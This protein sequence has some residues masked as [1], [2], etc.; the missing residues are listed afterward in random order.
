MRCHL[1]GEGECEGDGEGGMQTKGWRDRRAQ[2]L[3][4]T[5]RSQQYAISGGDS[6]RSCEYRT[7]YR[8]YLADSAAPQITPY[9]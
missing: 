5:K 7:G 8:M 3:R 4:L 6:R 2:P 1:R 9:G